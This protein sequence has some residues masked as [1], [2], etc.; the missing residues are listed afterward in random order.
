MERVWNRWRVHKSSRLTNFLIRHRSVGAE[1]LAFNSFF[2]S[3]P[4]AWIKCFQL[5]F[6][7][8]N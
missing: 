6:L 5:L 2:T 8:I 1:V 7:V 3:L 4:Q